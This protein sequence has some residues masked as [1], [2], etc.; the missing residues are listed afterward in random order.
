MNTNAQ[1]TVSTTEL[2]SAKRIIGF[3]AA[4]AVILGT[5]FLYHDKLFE[6]SHDV[7]VGLQTGRSKA[8][9][10]FFNWLSEASGEGVYASTVLL[11]LPFMSFER[12]WYLLVAFQTTEFAK[13]VFKLSFHEP[14]PTWVWPDVN[15]LG[16]ASSFGLPSGHCA[17]SANFV[18]V[19]LLDQFKQ[20]SWSRNSRPDLNSKTIVNSPCTFV[21]L[22]T[23]FF[24]Y[25]PLVVFDR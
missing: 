5:Q 12:F 1:E 2:L 21:G 6:A 8:S 11:L 9:F 7:I 19:V 25:W 3:G 20:S 15:P 16:C 22:V 4:L 14:R 17:E 13:C 18:L 24:T 10:D 23:L